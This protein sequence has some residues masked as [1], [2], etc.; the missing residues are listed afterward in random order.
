MDAMMQKL[1]R[2]GLMKEQQ[3][4]GLRR[5][6]AQRALEIATKEQE[7]LDKVANEIGLPS[8]EQ[9][10]VDFAVA[11]LKKVYAKAD[12]LTRSAEAQQEQFREQ[13]ERFRDRF[14]NA[15]VPYLGN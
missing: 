6:R 4:V 14:P 9:Q 11:R 5:Y 12:A 7:E 1:V 3:R 8:H 15:D 2:I 10:Q 13:M